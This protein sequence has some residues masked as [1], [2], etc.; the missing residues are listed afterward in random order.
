METF[1]G[2]LNIFEQDNENNR[3]YGEEKD[4]V[5]RIGFQT[6]KVKN[7]KLDYRYIISIN[8]NNPFLYIW[9]TKKYQNF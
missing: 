1:L 7:D 5:L 9:Q 3:N 4:M 6:I 2:N 8:I